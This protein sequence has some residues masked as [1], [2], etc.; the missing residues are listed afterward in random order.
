MRLFVLVLEARTKMKMKM[1][2]GRLHS[3][4]GPLRTFCPKEFCMFDAVRSVTAVLGEQSLGSWAMWRLTCRR[5]GKDWQQVTNPSP[6][7]WSAPRAI[8]SCRLRKTQ[9]DVYK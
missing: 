8:N 4:I 3:D 6:R 2:D 1:E 7:S 9:Q 5:L